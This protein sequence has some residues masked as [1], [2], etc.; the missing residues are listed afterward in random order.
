[1]ISVERTGLPSTI[2]FVDVCD[3]T[4]LYEAL[5]NARAQSLIAKT[6]SLLSRSTI[7]HVG[8]VVKTIGDEIM[9]QFSAAA[10]AMKASVDMQQSVKRA[11]MTKD[12]GVKSL[13]I[14]IGFHYGRVITQGADVFGDAV[15]VAA[16]VVAHA[17]P[18][19]ILV[20]KQTV[21]ILP[22]GASLRFVGSTHVKG[23]KDPLEF[24]EVVWDD[25]DLTAMQRVVQS[26]PNNT[27]LV[28]TFGNKTIELGRDRRVLNMGRG[29]ENDVVVSDQIA[30]RVHARIE[31]RHNRFV[32][33]DQSL[34]GTYLRT[35]GAVEVMLRRN[36]IAL[37]G[38][39]LISLGKSDAGQ[40]RCVRFAI[41]TGR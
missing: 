21:K 3:S 39:G 17:R 37:V 24:F 22:E 25:Q 38:S 36:E 5:G 7:R 10:D 18:G 20:S 31:W 8:T 14:R 34:N 35:Q 23:R 41:R 26:K 6:L 4:T 2:L 40:N 16:R 19:Q 33:V 13:A 11:I 29:T 27:W 1:M 12:I 28:A 9:C 32:L 30:S 15:N